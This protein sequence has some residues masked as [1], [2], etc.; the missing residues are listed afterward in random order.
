M[1]QRL[2]MTIVRELG[3]ET[4]TMLPPTAEEAPTDVGPIGWV[5]RE[6]SDGS[7]AAAKAVLTEALQVC[8]V[9][10]ALYGGCPG[11]SA[12][13]HCYTA[14]LL[15]GRT[16]SQ[17]ACSRVPRPTGLHRFSP[18]LIVTTHIQM[19]PLSCCS[20]RPTWSWRMYTKRKS[21]GSACNATR[22]HTWSLARGSRISLFCCI[23]CL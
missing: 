17:R 19:H 6:D 3:L 20:W 23:L 7:M 14:A 8:T 16:A 22:L 1:T 21:S 15:Q 12:V 11:A 18:D 2:G 13:L 9:P 5:G 10:N 4:N